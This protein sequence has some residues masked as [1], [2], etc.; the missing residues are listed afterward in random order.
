[1]NI[2]KDLIKY[3]EENIFPSYSKNDLAHNLDHINYVINR[4]LKFASTI[5]DI[6]YDMVYAIAAYHDIGHYIDPKNHEKLS[7]EML[8][9]DENLKEFFNDEEIKIMY[10]A[11]LEHRASSD[12]E[13]QNIYG[14]IVSSADRT[15][16]IEECLKRTYNYRLKH[17]PE[18]TLDEMVEESR[19]YLERKYG[20]N[21]YARQKNYFKDG[22][23][24]CYLNELTSLVEN[25]EKF[26]QKLLEVNNL[27]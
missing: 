24:D 19:S 20:K 2:N 11:V 17:N 22:D 21:G 23:Y 13:P 18:Y 14:K 16:S 27:Q 6:N 9:K 5:A 8:L 1:M 10:I 12:L 4:S 7:A 15:N 25:K 26:R 3:I